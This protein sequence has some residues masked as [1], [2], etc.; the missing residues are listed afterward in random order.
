MASAITGLSV[1]NLLDPLESKEEPEAEGAPEAKAREE[2]ERE[3]EKPQEH[4]YY[5]QAL[6]FLHLPGSEGTLAV[7]RT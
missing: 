2:R 7:A 1:S 5:R 3:R 4:P 6:N